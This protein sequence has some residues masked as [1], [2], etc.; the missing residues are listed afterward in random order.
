[1]LNPA[2]TLINFS[3]YA[4]RSDPWFWRDALA[5]S[6]SAFDKEST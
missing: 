3:C 2:C 6:P 4:T 5:A 1:M